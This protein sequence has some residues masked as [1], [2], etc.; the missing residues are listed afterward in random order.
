MGVMSDSTPRRDP[1]PGATDAFSLRVIAVPAFGPTV[2]GAL[3]QGA[4]LPVMV[5]RAR[6][7]GASVTVAAG[8]VA[9]VG[10]A[11][12]LA[13]L[14]AGAVVSR[15]GETRALKAAALVEVGAML[16]GALAPSLWVL[17]IGTAALGFEG[18]VFN[19]ARQ[20]YL[21]DAVPLS[22]RARALSTLGGVNRIGLFIGPFVGALAVHQGGI[23][24]AYLVGAV[25]AF[26]AFLLVALG[27]DLTAHHEAAAVQRS[28]ASVW[29]VLA[30]HRRTLLTLGGGILVIAGAR[31]CR[32]SV[33]PLYAESIGISA[34]DTSLVFGIAGAVDMLLFYPA[35]LVMDR[36]GRAW[37]A[38]PTV[39]VLGVGMMLLPLTHSIVPLTL[40]AMVMAFGNGIGS[41]IVMTLGADAAPPQARPQ[42]LGGWRL[43]ADLGGTA[44]PLLVGGIALVA[45]LAAAIVT[46]GALSFLGGGW[47]AYWVP[48]FDPVRGRG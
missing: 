2:L 46:V 31:A 29:S 44:G 47:L 35:G 12:M 36:W 1:S 11:L 43:M 25:A 16:T 33:L 22:M 21:T 27:P 48:R 34:S 7:L 17:A 41:G 4:V 3:G 26:A 23:R 15:I 14:P 28:G 39:L 6:E 10:F 32:T 37:I 24:A 9:L 5:L 38:V 19:L 8:M 40:V 18:A 42:F 13:A 45:P 20:A 30:S